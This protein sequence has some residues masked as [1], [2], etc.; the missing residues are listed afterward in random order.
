MKNGTLVFIIK[1]GRV[2]LAMKKRGFGVG[3][4]NGVGGKVQP[5]ESIAEAAVREA[6]EE[7]GVTPVLGEP[8]A[9]IRYHEKEGD[10]IGGVHVFR[11]DQYTGIPKESEEMRPQWFPVDALPL[12]AMWSGDKL[13]IDRV[14]ARRRFEAEIWYADDGS[15]A[16]HRVKD[17]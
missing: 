15:V 1:E 13:W 7:I 3:K 16:K 17:L 2:L 4:W 5:S 8:I 12:E 14:L 9:C 6:Q 11:T 10:W